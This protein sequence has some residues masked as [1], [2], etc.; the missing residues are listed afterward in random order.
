MLRKASNGQTRCI[1][2]GIAF[3][4]TL[5]VGGC[6]SD[7]SSSGAASGTG[8][9]SKA[10]SALP[11]CKS[12]SIKSPPSADVSGTVR[13]V[14]EQVPDLDA[15]KK[16]L[17]EFKKA[18][19][20]VNLQIE[21]AN[22][23]VI[24]DKEIASFQKGEGNYDLVPVDTAWLPEYASAGFLE[25]LGPSVA[26]LGDAYDYTDLAKSVRE[27]GQADGKVYG[28]PY[29][30]YPTGFVYRKDIWHTPPKTLDELVAKAKE[31]TKPDQA[32]L[33]LQPMQ[34]QTILE[35]WNPY[36]LAAGGQ[37]SD[38]ETGEWTIDSPEAKKA[39]E[40]YIDLYKTAAP[41]DSINWGFD[42]STRAASSGKA[43]ALSTYVLLLSTLNAS[44]T[45]ASGKF[46]IAPFPGGR[47]TGG[48]WSWGIPTNAKSKDAAWA[49]ISWIT[50][51]E[52]DKRRTI[53]G[54]APIRD[55]VMDDP[56]VWKS[57]SEEYFQAYKEIAA[58]AVPIC[59]GQGCAEASQKIGEHIN[60]AVAGTESV[61]DAL[62]G[63]QSDAEQATGQ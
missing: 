55:S 6:G 30:S 50:T 18:Y 13:V 23:D 57:A 34:G 16:L 44:G 39:L 59:R 43:T 38:S 24:R 9:P 31:L 41:K 51:K 63:A 48:S 36:L 8:D 3:I 19:P 37:L 12:D 45:P 49:W 53:L 29:Y 7:S 10:V 32:G 14:L 33:A 28:I 22:Y 56:E 47:G 21:E 25:D 26:C 17:P 1:A 5:L 62:K 40:T 46:R 4:A 15:L 11:A 54:G 27:V 60:A 2:I 35:E 58:N 20:N 42:E 52:Q 61:D